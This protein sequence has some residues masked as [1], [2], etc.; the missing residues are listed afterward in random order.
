MHTLRGALYIDGASITRK[1][2]ERGRAQGVHFQIEY[3]KLA[4]WIESVTKAEMLVR[5]YYTAKWSE[6][7]ESRGFFYQHLEHRGYSI[8]EMQ[9]KEFSKY[10]TSETEG[11]V[12]KKIHADKG[13]DVAIALDSYIDMTAPLMNL[14]VLVLATHDGDFVPLVKRLAAKKIYV[15]GF[16]DR[17]SIELRKSATPLFLDEA[18]AGVMKQS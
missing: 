12:E 7:G 11:I 2:Q 15:V 5:K 4:R 6:V 18:E 9:S 8:V 10:V 3:G 17:M 16:S 14:D 13:V 1:L